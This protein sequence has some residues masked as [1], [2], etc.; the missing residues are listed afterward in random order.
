[1]SPQL[2]ARRNG[3]VR[4]RAAAGVILAGLLI[5]SIRASAIAQ[6][7][8]TR[9]IPRDTIVKRDIKYAS[10]GSV[11]LK[12]DLYLPKADAPLPVLWPVPS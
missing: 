1:M 9:T 12:L 4:A 5:L 3:A 6:T 2:P 11:E 8:P 7:R 10:A